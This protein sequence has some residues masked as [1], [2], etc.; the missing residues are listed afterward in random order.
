MNKKILKLAIPNIIS[1]ISVPI[2]GMIDMALVGYLKTEAI[3]YVSA[4]ALGGMIFNFI[5]MSFVFLR[6]TTTGFTAQAYGKR[7]FTKSLTCLSHSLFVA[8]TGS[9]LILALQIPIEKLAFSIIQ[10]E[11]EVKELA[12][13]YFYIRIWAAPATIGLYSL[14]GWFIG[15]QNAKS[16]MIISILVNILNF[17]FSAFFVLVLGMKSEGV[18]LG[19]LLAQYTGFICAIFILLK[20]Y[21]KTFKYWSLYQVRKLKDIYKFF[22]VSKDI[23]IRTIC[24][25]SVFTFIT[26]KS[27]SISK[28]VL[29]INSLLLQ[30][31]HI[32]SYL[33]DGFAYAAEALV[34]RFIG[35]GDYKS[36]KICIKKLLKIGFIMSLIFSIVYLIFKEN[37]LYILTNDKALIEQSK[38]YIYWIIILPIAAFGAFIWDGIFI[39]ATASI[40]MR[41]SMLIAALAIFFPV[42]FISYPIIGNHSLWLSL[43]LFMLTRGL[44]LMILSPRVIY[45]DSK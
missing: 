20:Y 27:A 38:E 33:I 7:N 39:G 28:N 14:L 15:M 44:V 1:N 5:Y 4:I 6:M 16:P 30:F 18:A 29:A 26:Y 34:G 24:V 11:P 21:R 41:N 10:T 35:A 8:I 22:N 9:L 13:E 36:L 40:E 43:I 45:R 31:L 3:N 25:I 19:T 17:A 23:F 32:F 12:K 42:L 2:A 37:I